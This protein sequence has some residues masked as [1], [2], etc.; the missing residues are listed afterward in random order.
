MKKIILTLAVALCSVATLSAQTT[1]REWLD[2]LNASLGERYAVHLNL[3]MPESETLNGYFMVEGDSYYMTLG[4]ME[5]YSD[6]KLR[7]EVN[8][9]RKEVTEDRVDITS[10]DMLTNPTRAFDFVD[11]EF[12]ISVAQT[13]DNGSGVVLVLTPRSADYGITAIYLSIISVEGLS[14][15]HISEPTRPY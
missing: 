9:D 11:D 14:L 5:V 12:D 4:V 13:L 3:T 6:G 1:A 10:V 2:G 15:I 7:Y 8:N